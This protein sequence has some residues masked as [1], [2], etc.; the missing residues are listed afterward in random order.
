MKD[1]PEGASR[2]DCMLFAAERGF[3]FVLKSSP[4]LALPID[5]KA[6]TLRAALAIDEEAVRGM[7]ESQLFKRM[8]SSLTLVLLN[9]RKTSKM[10]T[11]GLDVVGQE[12]NLAMKKIQENL[13]EAVTFLQAG[14]TTGKP[15]WQ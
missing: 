6:Q 8:Q 2:A 1:I 15:A 14:L 12:E 5:P 9:A 7:L 11:P 13:L 3:G 4:E 10:V